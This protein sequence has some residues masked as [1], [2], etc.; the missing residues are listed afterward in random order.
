MPDWTKSMKQ[1]FE[2]YIVN[3]ITWK[4]EK[5]L[6]KVKSCSISWDLES[7]T[8]GSATFE[9]DDE[10]NENYIRIYLITTQNGKTEKHPLGTFLVQT[11]PSS[12]DGNKTSISADAYSPLLELKE[13][14]LPIG[15]FIPK[16]SNIMSN[17]YN[18][19]KENVRCPVVNTISD[20]TLYDDF[21]T[22][23]DDN[24]LK[25]VQN[26]IS[27]AKFS[28]RLD[29]LG[30]VI[31]VPDK[32]LDALQP[33]WTY[34]DDNSSIMYPDIDLD[35]D[36]YGIPN[37]IEVIATNGAE[38]IHSTKENNDEES[39]V[40]IKNRG[41]RIVHRETDPELN[42]IP[43]D[44]D[45]AQ[46]YIDEYAENLLKSLST[47]DNSISYQHAF[48]PVRIGDCVRINNDMI[49]LNNIK[50]IVTSQTIKCIPGC[51]VTEKAVFTTKLWR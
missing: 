30:R 9:L 34:T 27:N 13:K 19:V 24:C 1:T 51:P 22:D 35:R 11:L 42:G 28:Y 10:I 6:T 25:T 49:G 39:P 21:V 45:E 4:D 40:S 33:I 29:E 26:L 44:H 12:F 3:P 38:I 14:Y 36:L 20:K 32:K 50:A 37:V 31:F 18:I 47:L 46:S 5:R 8:F 7:D 16:R 43:S 23:P 15:Y 41:R 48:C 17:V 2:Y